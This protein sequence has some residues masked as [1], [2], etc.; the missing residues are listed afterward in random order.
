MTIDAPSLR[1]ALRDN[2]DEPE[3][4]ARNARAERIFADIEQSG[5]IDLLI[6]GLHHLMMVY[7]YSSEADKMFVPFARLLRLWEERPE[8][9]DGQQ[10]HSLFWMFKWVS[11]GMI[12]Q[13]H[14]PLDSIEKW[15]A[16]MDRRYRFAGHSER[17][18]RQ[19][20]LRIARHLGDRVRAERA[21]AGWLAAD[22]D[23]KSDCRACELHT[24]GAWLSHIGQD[25]AALE[26]WRPVLEGEF[27]CAHEP[28]AVLAE[29]L[30]PLLRLGRTDEARAHHLR[31]FRLVRPMESMRNAVAEHV[32][33][34]ALTGNEAR[35]LEI[36][37]ERPAYFTQTGEP[38][39]LLSYLAVTALLT[40]R[41]VLLG[42]GEQS[43]PGPGDRTWTAAELARYARDEALQLA[44]RFDK[45]NNNTHISDG[46]RQRMDRAPLLERLPLGLRESRPVSAAP[47]VPVAVAPPS[48]SAP[49]VSLVTRARELAAAQRPDAL[50]AW[51]AVAAA[52][53]EGHIELDGLAQA[54]LHD[55]LGRERRQTTAQSLAYLGLAAQQY[56]TAD[57]PGLALVARARAAHISCRDEPSDERIDKALDEVT[58]AFGTISARSSKDEAAAHQASQILL[59]RSR[60]LNVRL[61]L[62]QGS[63]SAIAALEKSVREHLAFTEPHAAVPRVGVTIGEVLGY[64]GDI[65]A[66]RSGAAEAAELYTRAAQVYEATGCPWYAVEVYSQLAR[67]RKALGDSERAETAARTALEHAREYAHSGGQARLH[68]QL[69]DYLTDAGDPDS[70]KFEEAIEHALQAAHWADEAGEAAGFGAYARHRLGGLLLRLGRADEGA[71]IL[72]AVLPELSADEHGDG[73]VVQ[74]LW[75]LGDCMTVLNDPRAAA[76]HWLKAADIAREWPEQR[77]HA[78][79]ANL[80]GEA[81]YRAGLNNEAERAY[82]RAGE[83]WRELGDVHALTRSMRV[84]AWLALREGQAGPTAAGDLMLSAAAECETALPGLTSTEDRERMCAEQAETYRQMGELLVNAAEGE[85]G[86]KDEARAKAARAAYEEALSYAKQAIEVFASLGEP[87]AEDRAKA[88][89][90][91]GWLEADLRNAA[92]ARVRAQGVLD[93]FSTEE[94]RGEAEALLRYAT[95][96]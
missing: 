36:L 29:S 74:T 7:N 42:H 49:A 91:A 47:A 45:R 60:I 69:V 30:I 41:L 87:C 40:E 11:S 59:Y 23:E 46:V 9:F 33:F 13:P 84:R 72:E 31:G 75:W 53:A 64:L 85:P 19:G 8:D 78:M 65:A 90:L 68:L 63:E 77:D 25:E 80:A 35:G 92:G 28:H 88:E 66:L 70:A 96:A 26:N 20:E 93:A 61:N 54:E 83:L 44:T 55:F 95:G 81:L 67:A 38:D 2:Y 57:E 27:T 1:Q 76:E 94:L 52:V 21:Y 17:A 86:D 14:I 79:L 3:G 6:D 50:A 37:A 58:T 71:V 43:V 16:E 89:L 62:T 48:D 10:T 73:T 18:V 39:S 34:C 32:E 24:Q 12:N 15:Q 5:D 56:E 4:Q 51:Q 82:R 22:R